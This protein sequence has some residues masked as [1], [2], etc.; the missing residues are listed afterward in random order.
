[1]TPG[2]IEMSVVA[3]CLPNRSSNAENTQWYIK[4]YQ[5]I[6]SRNTL[7]W[8]FQCKDMDIDIFK[9]LVNNALY[10]LASSYIIL[11]IFVIS[12]INYHN[13]TMTHALL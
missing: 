8:Q 6:I 10:V 13:I 5:L 12:L 7:V 3:P 2:V 11:I 9:M 4:M 1:M